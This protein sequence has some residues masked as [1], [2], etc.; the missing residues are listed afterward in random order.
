MTCVC[1]GMFAH[2]DCGVLRA[3]VQELATSS[4]TCK[5]RISGY[6]LSE[7]GG[8]GGWQDRSSLPEMQ[9]SGPQPVLLFPLLLRDGELL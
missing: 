2:V 3:D 4:H 8:E 9:P 5:E 7:S 1:T 6:L